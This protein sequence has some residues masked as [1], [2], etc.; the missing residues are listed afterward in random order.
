MVIT[1]LFLGVSRHIFLFSIFTVIIISVGL[2][3][4]AIGIGALYPRFNIEN[5]S[6]METSYGGIICIACSLIYVGL[7]LAIE[8][9]A[10]RV[11]I[12]FMYAKQILINVL[13]LLRYSIVDLFMLN[14]FAVGLPLFLGIR[15]IKKY[16]LKEWT[17]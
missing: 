2:S 8:A 4:I 17:M 12:R 9:R 6:Q 3:A 1:N 16:E 5:I 14:V 15:A 10:V 7:T 11:F 13:M